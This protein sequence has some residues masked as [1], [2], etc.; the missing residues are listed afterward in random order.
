MTSVEKKI[1]EG[2]YY[3]VYQVSNTRVFKKEKSFWQKQKMWVKWS[4]PSSFFRN[5]FQPSRYTDHLN[6]SLIVAK[7]ARYLL[8][9]PVF[10]SGYDYEQDIV[11]SLEDYF[12]NHSEEENRKRIDEYVALTHATW[13]LGFSDIVY[14]FT[15]NN[16]VAQDG[17]LV[18]H[19]FNEVTFDKERVLRDIRRKFWLT[20]SSFSSMPH[21]AFKDYVRAR[22]DESFTEAMLEKHWK[23]YD[24]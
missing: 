4:L 17:T 15:F 19:D 14:N 22:L 8:G 1:G 20:Q 5:L 9:N 3:D 12:K 18:L 21:G 2:L 24:R 13:Q 11:L 16:G 23:N 10:R 7:R 6:D